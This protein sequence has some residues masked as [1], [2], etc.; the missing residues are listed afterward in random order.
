VTYPKTL[1]SQLNHLS[2]QLRAEVQ[3]KLGTAGRGTLVIHY[4][5]LPGLENIINKILM[6]TQDS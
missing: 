2:E 4:P 5:D 3:I 6:Q 1:Q